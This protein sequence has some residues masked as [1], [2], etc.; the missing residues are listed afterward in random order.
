MKRQAT[1]QYGIERKTGEP[2]IVLEQDG[3]RFAAFS[4]AQ[5]RN[6]AGDIVQA[7]AR[8]E[9]DAMIRKFFTK[10]EFPEGACDALMMEFRKF[11]AE[12]DAELVQRSM[13]E[14]TLD[15]EGRQQ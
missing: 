4:V 6:F 15:G 7:C 11:R 12:L 5:A 13:S 8:A 9:A 3:K 2:V 10:Q 1:V 14:P